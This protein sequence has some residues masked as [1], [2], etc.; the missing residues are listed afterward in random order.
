MSIVHAMGGYEQS[1]GSVGSFSS[2]P[3]TNTTPG[4]GGNFFKKI[5]LES[6]RTRHSLMGIGRGRMWTFPKEEN[7][8]WFS[9]LVSRAKVSSFIFFWTSLPKSKLARERKSTQPRGRFVF[10]FPLESSCQFNLLQNTVSDEH[11]WKCVLSVIR[12]ITLNT[13]ICRHTLN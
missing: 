8:A 11:D 6:T 13:I 5:L 9:K 1:R 3:V 7:M 10:A 12:E 4:L 2:S